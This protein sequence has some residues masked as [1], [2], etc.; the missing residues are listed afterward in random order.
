MKMIVHVGL[1]AMAF[2]QP[3]FAATAKPASADK[4]AAGPLKN[5][6][7]VVTLDTANSKVMWEG[8]K[9]VG[10]SHNGTIKI[11]EGKLWVKSKK[12]GKEMV[13]EITGGEFVIDMN[14]IANE[15]L[16]DPEYNNK[17][18]SHLKSDDFFAVAKNP[19]AKF[20]IKSVQG[21]TVVGALTM[22]E[23]THDVTINADIKFDK[24]RK[25]W[26]A[27]TTKPVSLDRTKWG[28]MYGSKK[29]NLKAAQ[30]KIIKDEMIVKLDLVTSPV[31]VH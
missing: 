17:L 25:V 6:P 30:D 29:I 5:E 11:S 20:V 15:D 27:T 13:D 22:R 9:I 28:V 24:D 3:L 7:R 8:S 10:G 19:N 31:L 18:V 16:K 1:V 14:S 23:A 2:A 26:T 21:S 4:K 12:V